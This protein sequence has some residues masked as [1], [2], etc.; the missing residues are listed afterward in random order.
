MPIDR[1][2]PAYL[3]SLGGR[4]IGR[5]GGRGCGEGEG[6]E[7]DGAHGGGGGGVLGDHDREV[8]AAFG[9]GSLEGRRA[10]GRTP[11]HCWPLASSKEEGKEHG[12]YLRER[13]RER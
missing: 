11:C 4:G 2:V 7:G 6:E 8:S 1:C 10:R 5:R 13:E 12:E 3:E 9:G